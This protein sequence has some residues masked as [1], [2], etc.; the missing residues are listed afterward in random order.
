MS[1]S[2]S[3]T[4]W[5]LDSIIFKINGFGQLIRTKREKSVQ[6]YHKLP[7]GKCGNFDFFG[8]NIKPL[9]SGPKFSLLFSFCFVLVV[10]YG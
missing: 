6:N 1:R 7:P 9:L 4:T 2:V 8:R 5:V 10:L 3:P